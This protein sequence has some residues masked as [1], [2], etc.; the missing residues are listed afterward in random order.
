MSI[1]LGKRSKFTHSLRQQG[2]GSTLSST[3]GE[4]LNPSYVQSQLDEARASLRSHT[5]TLHDL[6]YERDI[7]RIEVGKTLAERDDALEKTKSLEQTLEALRQELA[8]ARQ[9]AGGQ[10]RLLA[11]LQR[12][13]AEMEASIASERRAW[14]LA[15][16]AAE[17]GRNELER[18]RDRLKSE[19]YSAQEEYRTLRAAVE[20]MQQDKDAL[21]EE[22]TDTR[23]ELDH[24]THQLDMLEER[25][26]VVDS[27]LEVLRQAAATRDGFVD[28]LQ[29]RVSSLEADSKSE[30][31]EVGTGGEATEASQSAETTSFESAAHQKLQE[32]MGQPRST[33]EQQLTQRLSVSASR[34]SPITSNG[35]DIHATTATADYNDHRR[36]ISLG[37]MPGALRMSWEPEIPSV[38]PQASRTHSSSRQGG[39]FASLLRTASDAIKGLFESTADGKTDHGYVVGNALVSQSGLEALLMACLAGVLVVSLLQLVM[40]PMCPQECGHGTLAPHHRQE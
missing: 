3:G 14:T 18:E 24:R 34:R 6:E 13:L 20:A 8:E 5:D 39:E 4:P 35:S 25:R 10:D 15:Q 21:R 28:Y 38:S 9:A 17:R 32:A 7:L 19:L 30:R 37:R 33:V 16:E 40:F 11:S 1:N 36:Q 29:D 2:S 31:H 12:P 22:L 23:A 26:I 27:G